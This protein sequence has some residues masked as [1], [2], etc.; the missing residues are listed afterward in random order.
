M[1]NRI[2]WIILGFVFGYMLANYHSSNISLKN[3]NQNINFSFLNE[4]EKKMEEK[5][6]DTREDK[7]EKITSEKKVYG[8]AAGLVASYG[9]MHTMFISPEENKEFHDDLSGEFVG[10]GVE[11]SNKNG[12]LTVIAPLV[13]SPAYKAGLKAKDVIV[14]ID[15]KNAIGMSGSRAV[16]LIRGKK[17]T[18]VKLKIARAGELKPFEVEIKRDKIKIPIIKTFIKDGIFV[19]KFYSFTENSAE[20][21]Y[22]K[23][24]TDFKNS[25]TDKMIID[26]RGN[27]GG[28]LS[29][30]LFISGLFLNADD[31]VVREDFGDEDKKD[32]LL[33]AGDMHYSDKTTNIF[34]NL[35][36]GILIDA[37]SASASE[38]LAGALSDY[39][40]AILFGENSFGKGTVQEVIDFD[41]GSSLKVTV[42][43]FIL[44]KSGWISYKGIT[45][46]VEIKMSD[47]EYKKMIEKGSF[48]NF[49]DSQ[50]Q[51]T[52]EYMK[53]IKNQKE[54]QKKV[55]DFAKKRLEKKKDEKKEKIEK[56]LDGE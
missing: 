22:K 45:P 17:G 2:L 52:I 43:K 25:K 11:I 4:V 31:V 24:I 23:I 41:N 27:S 12:L 53:K 32:K 44:P 7:S 38:I 48:S 5:F 19:V 40:K 47:E 20:E 33:K 13:G 36:L 15:A 16:K 3:S 29:A 18:K 28:F 14:E 49:V 10:I 56:V 39:H 6:I 8:A 42:A 55:E 37:G 9:D 34:K 35:K 1:R 30:A 21:F 54:F 51:K 50:L 46:D 26:L